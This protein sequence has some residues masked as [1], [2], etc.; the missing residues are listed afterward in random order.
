[1][2]KKIVINGQLIEYELTRKRVKNINLR[3]RGDGTIAVSCSPRTSEERVESFIRS[4]SDFILRALTKVNEK[5][6][7]ALRPVNYQTGE[8]VCIYGE[9]YVIRVE[10]AAKDSVSVNDSEVIIYCKNPD[11]GEYRAKVYEKWKRIEL[12]SKVLDMC[13]QFYPHFKVLG[14]NYPNSI[15]F[16]TM[17]SRWG[18]CKPK[19]GILT[20]NYNLFETPDRAIE[21]VVVHEFC[22]FLEANHSD[23]FYAQVAKVLPDWNARRKLLKDY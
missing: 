15:K 22:H 14:V 11:S 3:I 12:Q 18:S 8:Q 13:E 10:K 16:R 6:A 20:F 2:L 21:Y 23:R 4:N 17:T 1:M 9:P 5:S 19:A 7:R